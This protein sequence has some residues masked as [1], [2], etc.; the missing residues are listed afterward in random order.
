MR[1]EIKISSILLVVVILAGAGSAVMA[2]STLQVTQDK[3]YKIKVKGDRVVAQDK[4]KPVRRALEAQCARIA[5][6]Q[7]NKD[8]EALRALRTPDF[9][10]QMPDGQIWDLETSLNY[11][12]Q[13]FQQVE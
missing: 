11:S 1:Y 9:T 5:E 4:S 7:K 6:A 8:I 13:A 12:R 2:Q 3:E 10:V